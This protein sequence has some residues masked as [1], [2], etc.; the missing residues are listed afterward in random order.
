[1]VKFNSF[2]VDG[3]FAI[4]HYFMNGDKSKIY[5]SEGVFYSELAPNALLDKFCM[6]YASTM[7][8]RRQAASAF[9]NYPNRTPILVTPYTIGA[10]PT[11]SYK[12]FENVWIFNHPFQIESIE[13]DVTSITFVDGTTIKVN[14]SK[15]SLLQQQQKL[16]T[17]LDM[18]RNVENRMDKYVAGDYRLSQNST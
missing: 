4:E 13:K 6:R 18:F 8:G 3:V 1:M 7:E 17:M 12:S 2:L 9:L 16:H 5:T 11:H 15:Y 10:F 14:I